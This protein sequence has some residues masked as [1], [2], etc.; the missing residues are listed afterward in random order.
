M[1]YTVY[2]PTIMKS[3]LQ[4]T[5]LALEL[6]DSSIGSIAN[7]GKVSVWALALCLFPINPQRA[8]HIIQNSLML[9]AFHATQKATACTMPPKNLHLLYSSLLILA[10]FSDCRNGAET[11]TRPRDDIILRKIKKGRS[12]IKPVLP[13]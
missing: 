6:V 1:F 2:L 5:D 9:I 13:N 10:S 11:G 3:M 7:S 4:S 8:V 12:S